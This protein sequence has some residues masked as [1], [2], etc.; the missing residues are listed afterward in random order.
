MSKQTEELWKKADELD[1]HGAFIGHG[2]NIIRD[3]L[4]HDSAVLMRE[5]ADTIEKLELHSN[6]L[7]PSRYHELFGTPERAALTLTRNSGEHAVCN[8]PTWATSSC[9]Y[10][11]W[12]RWL[13]GD[14]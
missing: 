7:E 9:D 12:L 13:R 4:I 14:A 10:D 5:A 1:E 6:Q 8:L 11:A 3:S 2:G